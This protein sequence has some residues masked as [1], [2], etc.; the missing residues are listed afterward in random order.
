MEDIYVKILAEERERLGVS[1]K[2]LCD[3]ICSE[4]MYYK[5]ENGKSTL[6][7]ISIKRLLARLGVD[8]ANYD[9]YL[10]YSDYMVWKNRMDIINSIEDGEYEKATEMLQ[11]YRN[12]ISKIKN[13]SRINIEEQFY[14]FMELQIIRC[15]D[16]TN[17]NHIAEETY[18]KALMC[19]V[20]SFDI[21]DIH[22]CL[23]SPLELNIYIEYISKKYR[24]TSFLKLLNVYKIMITYIKDEKYGKWSQ[25][26]VYPK[27]VVYMYRGL[28]DDIEKLDSD[29][30]Y[31][32]Y[33]EILGYCEDAIELIKQRKSLLYLVELLE[34][35]KD[36]L[37]SLIRFL[38]DESIVAIW[39][40]K[41]TNSELYC[42]LLKQIYAMYGKNEYMT[43]DAFLYRESGMYC[44]NDIVKIRRDMLDKTQEDLAN[45]D[46]SVITIR[47]FE[48]LKKSVYKS[49]VMNILE[50]LSLYPSYVNL[51]IVTDK[52]EA[53]R[54]L[55]ELRFATASFRYNEVESLIAKLRKLVPMD[56]K[57]N[58]QIING[59][60]SINN[61][62]TGQIT[63]EE[64][65]G[66]LIDALEKTI[67][68]DEI[69]DKNR[70]FIT[71]EEIT[72]LCSIS[73]TYKEL[74]RYD[75][76]QIYSKI[77]KK[78]MDDI[79]EQKLI[80]GRIGIYEMVMEY[81]ANLFGDLGMFQ[82][83]NEISH[84]LIKISLKLR[85][86]SQIHPNLYNI[87]WNNNEC[88]KN[89][90]SFNAELNNCIIFSQLTGDKEDEA[91]YRNAII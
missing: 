51:G 18:K 11:S 72:L 43:N 91:F 39:N 85:R 10:E 87:A 60:E 8:N 65:I 21:M 33:K 41:I 19:T 25:L 90:S 50:Q 12:Y 55:D 82:E 27:I 77:M 31:A 15:T 20:S 38:N 4:D 67:K 44:L 28:I 45:D 70:I 56:N 36:I 78:Y 89:S 83:S 9:H 30:Q 68:L 42:N 74:Q 69:V 53:L 76:A 57:I 2:V 23:M 32:I 7:R 34:I 59:M 86:A 84:K 49:N 16:E 81:I 13:K 62:R 40:E 46:V 37:S 5:V 48:K 54:L 88:E 47:R 66:N 52:K 29:S 64:H 26:K 73:S 17:Y 80:D 6:D 14:I 79:E 35:K 22:R 24:G 61:I 63:S 71:T 1:A 75:E 58:Q 3:G